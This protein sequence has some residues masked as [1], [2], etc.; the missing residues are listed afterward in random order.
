MTASD[1]FAR[2]LSTRSTLPPELT[3]LDSD[4]LWAALLTSVQ[5]VVLGEIRAANYPAL[6]DESQRSTWSALLDRLGHDARV[7]IGREI[8]DELTA[9]TLDELWVTWMRVA[10]QLGAVGDPTVQQRVVDLLDVLGEVVDT[11]LSER[12]AVPGPAPTQP[13]AVPVFDWAT[14]PSHPVVARPNETATPPGAPGWRPLPPVLVGRTPATFGRRAAAYLIDRAISIL[15]TM[16]AVLLFVWPAATST[17]STPSVERG[18]L[19]VA[20]SFVGVA[21]VSIGWFVVVAWLVGRRGASPGKRLMR[22]EVVGFS[23]PGPIGFGRALLR[24]L[25]LAAFTIGNVITAW[26]PYASVFWDPS[27]QLRGWH[28][29]AVDDVVVVAASV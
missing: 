4:P 2:A 14:D 21:A 16:A 28:D 25:I 24:E 23:S 3:G 15:I 27:K 20:L 13:A 10:G 18:G 12:F 1:P 17:P 22:I 19:L 9:G 8:V 7:R 26:L 6:A 29:R 5:N 11:Q